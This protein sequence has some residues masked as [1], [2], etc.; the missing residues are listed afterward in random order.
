MS[1]LRHRPFE[2]VCVL[3]ISLGAV[4]RLKHYLTN[5][6]LWTDEAWVAVS[7]VSRSFRDIFFGV[8][9]F[10]DFSKP[11]LGFLL[12]AKAAVLALGNHEYALRLFPLICGLA[13]IVLFVRLLKKFQDK[14][15]TVLALG[16]FCL[17]PTLIYYSAELKQY[18]LDLLTGLV[19]FLVL[20]Q[21]VREKL[22]VK[23]VIA[24]GLLGSC[25]MW[26]S[27]AA[28]FILAAFGLT[29]SIMTALEK[30]WSC[31]L[32][33]LAVYACWAVS[34]WF[35]YKKFLSGMAGNT[36]LFNSWQGAV[37]EAPLFSKAALTWIMT[38]V[39]EMF[40]N[41]LD[42][43]FSGIGLVLFG[44]GVVS[45]FR[46]KKDHALMF[47]FAILI[48]LLAAALH[49]YPFRGRLL[50]FLVPAV[51]IFVVQ[52]LLSV[53][54]KSPKSFSLALI[55]ILGLL[56][57]A[58]ALGEAFRG[59]SKDYCREESREAIAFVKDHYRK[60]DSLLL[61]SAAQFPLWYYG[62]RLKLARDFEETWAGI[63]NGVP[64]KGG[65]DRQ[66]L[67]RV[68]GGQRP[69]VHFFPL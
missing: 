34:F 35:L 33:S 60:G 56:L 55:I 63:E 12:S 45:L 28:L 18:S 61:N 52:G 1:S 22:S 57:F 17:S 4:L 44:V 2:A 59:F 67:G 62:S 38:V 14:A 54:R 43:S 47:F 27:N 31:L 24:L 21:A 20:G 65:Q 6:S 69:A 16:S 3:L 58:G 13:S 25:A 41:P 23:R 30:R 42:F 37:L 46:T 8:E 32:R 9:I 26:M 48:A 64:K 68:P 11:P 50:L 15:L 36:A 29:L 19:L 40:L 49:K 10:P 53:G 51:L 66:I 39:P 5:C 7:I